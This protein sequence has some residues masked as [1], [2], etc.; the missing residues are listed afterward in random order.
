MKKKVVIP[1][2]M[3][4]FMMFVC[5]IIST[6]IIVFI[7][8]QKD[9]SFTLYKEDGVVYYKEN[10]DDEYIKMNNTETKL[11]DGSFVKTE[12]GYAHIIFPDHSMTS[13]DKNTEIQIYINENGKKINQLI[14][15]TWH[16]IKSI[17]EDESY[18]VETSNTVATVRGTRFAVTAG[19]DF[20]AMFTIKGQIEIG[21]IEVVDDERVLPASTQFLESGKY[22]TLK[23]GDDDFTIIDI[24]AD[25]LESEWYQRNIVIDEKFEN[26][27]PYEFIDS[28]ISKDTEADHEDTD[29]EHGEILHIEEEKQN[30]ISENPD[31][32]I[33]TP[34]PE[35]S[36]INISELTAYFHEY[37]NPY[38]VEKEGCQNI[39]TDDFHSKLQDLIDNEEDLTQEDKDL[40]SYLTILDSYCE[41]GELNPPE[42]KELQWIYEEIG[43]NGVG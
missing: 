6:A 8:M 30:E 23:T 39:N 37:F 42:I 27:N 20:S 19:E 36:N 41:D 29:H 14:G 2:L 21:P 34:V 7:L 33:V 43:S 16:R 12:E 24:P 11:K 31:D 28:I 26:H 17:V 13:I 1:S 22:A 25:I 3:T 32:P 9:K 35:E 18:S 5:C 15:N 10:K 38:V 4:V 40:V